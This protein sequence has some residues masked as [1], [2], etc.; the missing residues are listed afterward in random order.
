MRAEKHSSKIRTR[1]SHFCDGT[2]NSHRRQ[3]RLQEFLT[4]ASFG[5]ATPLLQALPQARKLNLTSR[6]RCT[7]RY[8]AVTDPLR[9]QAALLHPL[10]PSAADCSQ[11]AP[12]PHVSPHAVQQ[13]TG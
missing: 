9:L 11:S 4:P 10:A 7:T 13:N 6:C 3:E 12:A 1:I 5:L 8:M 2:A